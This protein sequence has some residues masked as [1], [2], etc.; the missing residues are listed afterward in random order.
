MVNQQLIPSLLMWGMSPSCR[1]HIVEPPVGGP[2]FHL[3][4]FPSSS[5]L[6]SFSVA[7]DLANKD[8]Q[9]LLLCSSGACKVLSSAR[10][11][12]GCG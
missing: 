1:L 5:Q 12:R 7:C 3:C 6:L 4:F 8:V 2:P 9:F 10:S 11:E